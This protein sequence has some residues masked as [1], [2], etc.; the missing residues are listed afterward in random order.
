MIERAVLLAGDGVI[1]EEHL[2]AEKMAA[3]AAPRAP[4]ARASRA[5]APPAVEEAARVDD[6][7]SLH[8]DVEELEKRRILAALESC[9]G[10]QTRAARMLGISRGT[11]AARLEQFGIPRPRPRKA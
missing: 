7:G 9:A 4:S 1:T 3:P 2:P 5:A 6:E 8:A 10:N 11:L